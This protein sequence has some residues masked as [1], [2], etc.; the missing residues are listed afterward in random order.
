MEDLIAKDIVQRQGRMKTY[1]GNFESVWQRISELVLPRADNF[2]GQRYPG[3]RQADNLIFDSTGQMAVPVFAAA[4]E[5]MVCPR[6]QKWHNLKPV[7]PKLKENYR[8][9]KYLED[10]R[11]LLFRVRYSPH[12]NFAS[13]MSENFISLGAFGNYGIFTEDGYHLGIRYQSIPLVEL[14]WQED[15]YGTIDTVHRC[16]KLTAR[17]AMQRESWQQKMPEAVKTAAEKEPERQFEFIHCVMPNTERKGSDK[18]WRGYAF[19]AYDVCIEGMV[20]LAEGGFRTMP[21]AIGRDVT[22]PGEVY[23]RGSAWTCLSDMRMLQEMS[24]TAIR[25]AQ[26]TLDPPTITADLDSMAP[27]ARRAGAINAGYLSDQ[28]KPLAMEMA[29]QADP[30]AALDMQNQR[31]DSVNR[32]FLVPF[33]QILVDNPQMTATEAMLRAQEKGALIAPT[34]S[35]S[36][37]T[38]SLVIQREIDILDHAGVFEAALGPM[39]DELRADGMPQIQFDSP[40]TRAQRSQEGVGIIQT[41]E[42]IT[43]LANIDPRVMKR[44]NADEVLKILADVNGA[45]IK[46]LY[47]D[48]EMA[49]IDAQAA[50]KE[51]LA[52]LVAAAP[53]VAG[54]AKDMAQAGKEAASTPF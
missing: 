27:Y 17:Q 28:G 8:V 29:P 49:E 30:R 48:D 23:A 14:Y 10:M 22:G 5:S 52:N 54:A 31:R 20:T 6:T 39:P 33:F 3:Q 32:S 19:C 24:K 37:E 11:D 9:M 51:Q 50:Q 47:S 21:Y 7:S 40:L 34:M 13:V 35:R 1:R 12:T 46:I 18:S 15:S 38:L 4:V 53:Q 25:Y 45:P 26:L 2:L 44:I 42:A 36:Q 16:Y 41:I 43:P